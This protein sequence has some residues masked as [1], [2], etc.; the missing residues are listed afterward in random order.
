[1][2]ALRRE[3]APPPL[4][5]L[6]PVVAAG[7]IYAAAALTWLALGDVLPGGRWLAVHLFTV[8]V[9]SNLVVGLTHHFAQ[10]LLHAPGRGVRPGRLVLLNAGAVMLLAGLP[11]GRREAVAVGATALAAAVLWLYLDLR[12][13]RRA[14]LTGRF[15]F[16]V[17]GYERACG[18]F[19]HGAVLGALLGV[20]LVSGPWYAAVRLAHLHTNVLG[21]GGLTLLATVVFFGPTILRTRI[22]PGADRTATVALR[23]GAVGLTVATAGLVLTGTG[24]AVGTAARLLAGAGVATY[25]AAATAICL[26]VLRAGRR[27]GEVHAHPL[28]AGLVWFLVGVWADVALVATGSW[29]LL[30]A[31]GAAFVVGVLAQVILA[32]LGHLVPMVVGRGPARR[33]ALRQRLSVAGRSR[34]TAFN[35]G[36]ALVV[37]VAVAGAGSPGALAARGGWFLI[38]AAVV[39][40]LLLMASAVARSPARRWRA[41]PAPDQP[42]P[43]DST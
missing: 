10:T 41:P 14:S 9:L 31:V 26:P 5:P 29:R 18:A 42:T 34:A 30:D 38:T 13:L 16:V 17:R 21:W 6:L 7:G 43:G 20:G 28:R 15:A 3:A 2:P 12:R 4:A 27:A 19:L 25:A 1:M 11:L 8:G 33:A 32:A 22:E 24:G 39:A 40:Q 37:A 36:L 23:W 35:V